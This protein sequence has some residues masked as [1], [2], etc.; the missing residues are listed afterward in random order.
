MQRLG[1]ADGVLRR[2]GE[3]PEP[4]LLTYS[5]GVGPEIEHPAWD[6]PWSVPTAEDVD[7]LTDLGLVR[8]DLNTNV[9]R[10]FSLTVKGREQGAVLAEPARMYSGGHAP[11]QAEVLDWLIELERES[12]ESFDLP[13]RLLDKAVASGF[14]AVTGREELAK[15]II[16]L[17]R[18]GFLGGNLLD[19]QQATAEQL[20]GLSDGLELTMRAHGHA[21]KAEPAA[22]PSINFYAPVVA[23]Q[24]AAGDIGNY[25]NL[26]LL[27]DDAE[28]ELNKLEN[29]DS[30][31][32]EEAGRLLG[33]LRGK[34]SDAAGGVLTG[35]GGALLANVLSRLLGLPV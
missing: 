21:H 9:T 2:R 11:R 6:T 3:N 14:V 33:I 12:P 18:Q 16:G 20:L 30:T 31:V 28:V 1:Q 27:F 34:T 25:T 13:I 23:G 4:F 19:L 10:K 7:D 26:G 32:R 15:R 8:I 22:A 24:I 5:M 29:V 35:A 17:A